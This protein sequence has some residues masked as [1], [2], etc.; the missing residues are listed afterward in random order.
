MTADDYLQGIRQRE[1]VDTG[2]YSPVRGVQS[3]I[4]PAIQESA[5][6]LHLDLSLSGSFGKGTAIHSGADIALLSR[7][8][9]TH[10]LP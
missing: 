3:K 1:A 7:W 4:Q 6:N 2:I 10:P 5:G 8:H 9:S